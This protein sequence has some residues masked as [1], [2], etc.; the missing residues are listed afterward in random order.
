VGVDGQPYSGFSCSTRGS[1]WSQTTLGRQQQVPAPLLGTAARA[2]TH[3]PT[4]HAIRLIGKCYQMAIILICI[5]I[6]ELISSSCS[7]RAWVQCACICAEWQFWGKKGETG[8]KE[9]A[10]GLCI[11]AFRSPREVPC[12]LA[13]Q[14]APLGLNC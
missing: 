4:C 7:L 12:S 11:I 9:E 10:A 2:G 3:H 14:D 13:L 5:N 1:P 8:V 6:G